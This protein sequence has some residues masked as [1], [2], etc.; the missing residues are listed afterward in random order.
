MNQVPSGISLPPCYLPWSPA[1]MSPEQVQHLTSLVY[2][3]GL[4]N[5]LELGGG[6]STLCLYWALA[7]MPE[8]HHLWTIEYSDHWT[9]MLD[10]QLDNLQS[11]APR[12]GVNVHVV[13]Y[14]N[15]EAFSLPERDAYG[16]FAT[17]DLIL[18]DGPYAGADPYARRVSVDLVRKSHK[19]GLVIFMDDTDRFGEQCVLQE[20][21]A[22]G[23]VNI[24]TQKENYCVFIYQ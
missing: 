9:S 15:V 2:T 10:F 5:V 20:L 22:I 17:P 18:I 16:D 12:S 3:R 21:L 7:H 1:S 13:F 24:L 14:E 8:E 6:I 19:K 11:Q 4:P 23:P